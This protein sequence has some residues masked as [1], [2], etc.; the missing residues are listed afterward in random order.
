MFAVYS[1]TIKLYSNVLATGTYTILGTFP[2]SS[3]WL[4]YFCIKLCAVDINL[5][6]LRTISVSILRTNKYQISHIFFA[7]LLGDGETAFTS[8]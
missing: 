7:T 2:I 4:Y 8:C 3:F 6:Q 5:H 1:I